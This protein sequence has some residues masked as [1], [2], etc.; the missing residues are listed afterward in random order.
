MQE[1]EF[2]GQYRNRHGD[3][4]KS[5]NVALLLKDQLCLVEARYRSRYNINHKQKLSE[6]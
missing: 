3:Y 2:L 4:Y 5:W 6:S 1:I